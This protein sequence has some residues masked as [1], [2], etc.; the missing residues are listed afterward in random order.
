VGDV[1]DD[2]AGDLLTQQSISALLAFVTLIAVAGTWA[3]WSRRNLARLRRIPIRMLVTGTR[4]KSST[5][6]LIHAALTEG[7]IPTLGKMTGAA[8]RELDTAGQE[9]PT[10]R[11]GQVSI[12]E[13]LEAV[14]RS[15]TRDAVPPEAIVLECM[16]VTPDLIGICTTQIV[17]PQVSI[18]TNA[19]W[20]HLEEQGTDLEQIAISLS[21][22]LE[23][24][25]LA[26]TS[27]HR[28]ATRAVLAYEAELRDCVLDAVDGAELPR[29]ILDQV[30]GAHP[31][32]V[33]MAIAAAAYAGVDR[34]T[35]VRGMARSTTEPIPTEPVIQE[36]DGVRWWYRDIGS[37]NDTDSLTLAL[38]SARAQLPPG[39]VVLGILTTRWDRPLRAIQFAASITPADVDGL[40]I[41]GE[42]D[43]IVRRYAYRAGWTRDRIVRISTWGFGER[44][45]YRRIRDLAVHIHG[46][47]PECIA[48]IG[49]ESNHQYV[50]D[51]IRDRMVG[52]K[53]L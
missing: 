22:S 23:G 41:V 6:R 49:M 24:A 31:D 32:N 36:I 44:P 30:P 3:V 5:V 52:R 15:F 50:A 29:A 43:V 17:Q 14:H 4:G 51:E 7:N 21:R 48:L 13:M 37:T 19:L 39:A 38:D 2:V 47:P 45:L 12:L 26:I 46:G 8:S 11:I 18:V 40:I 25:R 53:V 35:A 34:D 9:H 27:E 42:P 1:L 10:T 33:A 28:E 16:A 20:D